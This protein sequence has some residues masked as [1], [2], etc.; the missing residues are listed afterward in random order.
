VSD[1]PGFPALH[2]AARAYLF[3]A[4]SPPAQIA[5]ASAALAILTDP[6]E[7]PR[8]REALW[9]NVHALRETLGPLAVGE[10]SPIVSVPLRDGPRAVAAWR[11]ALARGVYVNLVLPPGCRRGQERLRISVSAAHHPEQIERAGRALVAA[12][13]GACRAS[14]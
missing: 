11:G 9:A 1:H 8:L 4:S 7:G 6:R 3:T 12:V 13:E 14:S 5:A 10:A 2:L